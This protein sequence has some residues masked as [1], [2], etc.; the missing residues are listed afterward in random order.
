MSILGP[1]MATPN[2]LKR[3]HADSELNET[4]KLD[5]PYN[6]PQQV[7]GLAPDVSITTFMLSFFNSRDRSTNYR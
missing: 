7:C 4:V 2:S 1:P 5:I 6:I 3:S